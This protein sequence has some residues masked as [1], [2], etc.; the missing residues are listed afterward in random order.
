[1][2]NKRES[3]KGQ[4]WQLKDDRCGQFYKMYYSKHYV[5]LFSSI[6]LQ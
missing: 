1:M 5:D 3:V 2:Y 6:A 4:K